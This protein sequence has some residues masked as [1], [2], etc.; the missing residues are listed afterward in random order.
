[1]KTHIAPLIFLLAFVALPACE[2]NYG[3]DPVAVGSDEASAPRPRS[4]SQFVRA[5]FADVLGRSPEVYDFVIYDDQGN[6]ISSFE[7]DESE[8]LIAAMDSV[9]DE[10]VMRSIVATGLTHS[11]EV[12]L[13]SKDE[14]DD[15][16]AFIGD[17]FRRLLGREPGA[18]ELHAFLQEWTAADAVGP[19]EI[20]RALVGSREYQSY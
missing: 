4:N 3:F 8:F 20:V 2:A 14:V 10:R 13:P 18:Y 6:E 12:A 9:A 7:V 5:V 17:Q 19:H 1:M 11:T 16:E 15:P